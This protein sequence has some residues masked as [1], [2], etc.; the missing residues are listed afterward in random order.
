MI[1][2]RFAKGNCVFTILDD[3]SGLRS[4]IDFSGRDWSGLVLDKPGLIGIGQEIN[5]FTNRFFCKSGRVGI[6][7]VHWLPPVDAIR[8]SARSQ[9]DSN[10][11][12]L[13]S[14]SR[15]GNPKQFSDFVILIFSCLCFSGTNF[16]TRV[17]SVTEKELSTKE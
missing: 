4:E 7:G 8:S 2:I 15:L 17:I 12:L 5:P 11:F 10:S 13:R 3:S 16:S 14:K 9:S 6:N 1:R